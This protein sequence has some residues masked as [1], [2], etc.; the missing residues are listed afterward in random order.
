MRQTLPNASTGKKLLFLTHLLRTLKQ[1]S[2]VVEEAVS[3]PREAND[4]H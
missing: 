4:K 1:V 3:S 2:I